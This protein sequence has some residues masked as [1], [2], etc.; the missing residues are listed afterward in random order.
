MLS[1]ATRCVQSFYCVFSRGGSGSGG[2]VTT[3]F[4]VV[5]SCASALQRPCR[6]PARCAT[7]KAEGWPTRFRSPL[8]RSPPCPQQTLGRHCGSEEFGWCEETDD[9]ER[10]ATPRVLTSVCGSGSAVD[11]RVH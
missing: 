3:R 2:L 10:W 4:L 9:R 6:D 11:R 5:G 7:D 8:G 1:K